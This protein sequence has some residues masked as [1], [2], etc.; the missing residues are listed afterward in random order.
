MAFFRRVLPLVVAASLGLAGSA[1]AQDPSFRLNNRTG[2]T[3]SEVY[4]SSANENGWGPDR[5]GANVLASG[6]SLTIRL[7]GGQ[8]VND[9][10]VVYGNGRSQEW[11]QR[12]TCQL[13]DFNIQ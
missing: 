4:V 7:P 5:L 2:G 6:Q 13:T 10:K 3:I 9:I 1:L 11:R 12:N 8:C